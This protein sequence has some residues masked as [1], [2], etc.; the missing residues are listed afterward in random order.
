VAARPQTPAALVGG[1]GQPLQTES[2]MN[3]AISMAVEVTI[4]C[5]VVAPMATAQAQQASLVGTWQTTHPAGPDGPAYALTETY[6]PNGACYAEWV[7]A[8]SP[9]KV[10]VIVREKCGYEM[11]GPNTVRITAIETISCST[12]GLCEM[13]TFPPPAQG[14]G[15]FTF[16]GNQ[17]IVLE[18]GTIYVRLR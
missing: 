1:T 16:R 17:E 18:D 9:G 12:G 10:G 3:Q 6:W 4:A 2:T 14:T 8:P 7:I 15:S 5:L 11:L 13:S